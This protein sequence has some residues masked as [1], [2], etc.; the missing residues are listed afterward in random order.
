MEALKS[1]LRSPRVQRSVIWMDPGFFSEVFG[2]WIASGKGS[3]Q[4]HFSD[5]SMEFSNMRAVNAC[6]VMAI[7]ETRVR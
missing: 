7:M 4:S 5:Q 6:L 3:S 2:G 1:A